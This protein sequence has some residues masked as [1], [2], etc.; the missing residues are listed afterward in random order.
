MQFDSGAF[1]R[2]CQ[3][4][5]LA[6][7]T[8]MPMHYWK[9]ISSYCMLARRRLSVALHNLQHNRIRA[10]HTAVLPLSCQSLQANQWRI[11]VPSKPKFPHSITSNVLLSPQTIRRLGILGF[12]K[13]LGTLDR[14]LKRSSRHIARLTLTANL[15]SCSSFEAAMSAPLLRRLS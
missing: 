14:D 4:L 13:R 2:D 3:S 10:D 5:F 12:E 1:Q 9:S 6:L 8:G 11:V 15:V 7:S